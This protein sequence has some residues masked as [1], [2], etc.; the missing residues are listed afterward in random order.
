MKKLIMLVVLAV[1]AYASYAQTCN[2]LCCKKTCEAD[3]AKKETASISTMRSDLQTVI[4][5]MSRSSMAFDKQLTD[6]TVK[7]CVC[8]EEGLRYLS[9]VA[10]SIRREFVQKVDPSKLV[11]SLK[12]H[13]R[14]SLPEQ[15]TLAGLKKEIQLLSAQ[16]DLL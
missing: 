16:A 8:D 11:A 1:A 3:K 12:E 7:N 10:T 2:P 5:K 13:G 6:L 14:A 15:Q 9:T 4:T